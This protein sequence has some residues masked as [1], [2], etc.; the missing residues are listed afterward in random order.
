[1]VYDQYGNLVWDR[2]ITDTA[3]AATQDV[4]DLAEEV[5]QVQASVAQVSDDLS[6]LE[7]NLSIEVTSKRFEGTASDD[8]GTPDAVFRVTR[9]VGGTASPHAFRDQTAFKP[10]GANQAACSFDAAMTSS[11]SQNIDHTV[12]FQSRSTHNGPGSVR[13]VYGSES[14]NVINAA[15]TS[16]ISF[17]SQDRI[18]APTTNVWACQY[19]PAIYAAVTNAYGYVFNPAVND[20]ASITNSIGLRI[21]GV[22]G[23]GSG[24]VTN[25]YGVYIKNQ[26][27][28]ANR[29]PIYIEDTTARNY[30][31]ALT[32]INQTLQVG[33]GSRLSLGGANSG[34]YPA[35]TWNYDPRANTYIAALAASG[36][37]WSA[38]NF[39]FRA[40][41]PGSAG[42][43]PTFETLLNIH[44]TND[45]NYGAVFPGLAGAQKLGISSSR[46]SEVF[47]VNGAINTSDA[48]EKTAVRP[49]TAAEIN[50]AKQLA[51]EIGG[52]KWLAAVAAKGEAARTHIGMTVQR[53]VEIMQANSLDPFAYGFICYDQW[54]EE[55]DDKG[56]ITIPAGDA[57]SFRKDEL[58]AFIL[59]G[60]EAR[61]SALEAS[62]GEG[63]AS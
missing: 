8:A 7:S 35:I 52:F 18:N 12:G 34:D 49:L 11:S 46:W 2:Y 61:I 19:R 59:A 31:G 40:A 5:A 57:Y 17:F 27:L 56:N 30:I 45:A 3:Y 14:S 4:A 47:A 50:A 48:R 51:R 63:V 32:Q 6:E 43:T 25:E 28:G 55:R 15:I 26:T 24:S 37:Q 13:I 29:Y 1:M 38:N 42:A 33:G 60:F 21:E 16:A 22:Q 36:F 20:G 39:L 58:H 53:A 54:P 9:T 23:A 41:P 10:T 44:T 62:S